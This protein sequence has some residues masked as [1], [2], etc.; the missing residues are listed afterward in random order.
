M[1]AYQ[2][3]ARVT[4][5]GKLSIPKMYTK[6]LLAGHTVQ[7]IVLVSEAHISPVYLEPQEDH[8]LSL[9]EVVSQIQQTPPTPANIE[10]A[11]G[12]LSEYLANTP[13]DRDPN[14][15]VATWNEDW[16]RLE[17]EMEAASLAHEEEERNL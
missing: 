6:T 16:D 3:T 13:N 2:F 4:P 11:T 5:D 17:T 7:V 14:F 8:E 12:L 10:P 15:N 1:Q 9:E